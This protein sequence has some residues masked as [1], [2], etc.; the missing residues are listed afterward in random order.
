M[1]IKG[2]SHAKKYAWKANNL[3]LVS[4]KENVQAFIEWNL[5]ETMLKWNPKVEFS[6]CLST[7]V[8][9]DCKPFIDQNLQ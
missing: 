7:D 8:E 9:S 1:M 6:F 2:H 5:L 3:P 4:K